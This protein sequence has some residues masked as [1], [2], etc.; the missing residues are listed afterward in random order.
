MTNE[1]FLIIPQL[2]NIILKTRRRRREKKKVM[3]IMGNMKSEKQIN[4]ISN[5]AVQFIELF[6]CPFN[7][8][9]VSNNEPHT[10]CLIMYIWAAFDGLTKA[11]ERDNYVCCLVTS[12]KIYQISADYRGVEVH[13]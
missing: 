3:I 13:M 12:L 10:L 4:S 6:C 8:P 11:F 7:N 9:H 2:Q 1:I 5:D